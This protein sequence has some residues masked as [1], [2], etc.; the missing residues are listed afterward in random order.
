M[1]PGSSPLRTLRSADVRRSPPPGLRIGYTAGT[2]RTE[3][4]DI[5]SDTVQGSP[6]T[7]ARADDGAVGDL[8]GLFSALSHDLR[9]ALNGISVWTHI[10]ERS[11][12][13]TTLRAV[14]G[15][16]RAVT[17]QSMLAAELSEVSRA[18]AAVDWP[19]HL[20]LTQVLE[21]AVAAARGVRPDAGME[22]ELQA[23]SDLP[24][25]AVPA[26]H[27]RLTIQLLLSDLLMRAGERAHLSV[28]AYPCAEAICVRFRLAA[29]DRAATGRSA[30][31][32]RSLREILALLV[33]RLDGIGISSLDDDLVLAIPKT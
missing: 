10:L 6:A 4:V 24:R 28:V 12:D 20:P 27:V 13:E 11:A 26:A 22:I 16:R 29:E 7:A 17:Q 2:V 5:M 3:L 30:Q 21:E 32:R 19:E 31:A 14:E 18:L 15:I 25:A 23:P 9:A 33:S 8:V 1:Q